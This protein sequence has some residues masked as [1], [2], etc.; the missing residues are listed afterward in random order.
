M[1]NPC[2]KCLISPICTTICKPRI[3]YTAI[4]YESSITKDIEDKILS[5]IWNQNR[6]M[7]NNELIIERL[8]NKYIEIIKRKRKKI[9][10]IV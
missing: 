8:I 4:I 9:K 1:K 6:K 7:I 10:E 5:K 2:N 3:L